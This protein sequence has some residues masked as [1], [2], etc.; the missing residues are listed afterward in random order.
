MRTNTKYECILLANMDIFCNFYVHF[1]WINNTNL[2]CI[3]MLLK[4]IKMNANC[5]F[6]FLLQ[7]LCPRFSPTEIQNICWSDGEK[8]A[9]S[10]ST[11]CGLH[12]PPHRALCYQCPAHQLRICCKLPY[13]AF[14]CKLRPVCMC[15]WFFLFS[16][17][18]DRGLHNWLTLKINWKL[19]IIRD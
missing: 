9:P 5:P 4:D 19:E 18:H 12:L 14:R 2:Y 11:P 8:S 17:S 16:L 7:I 10:C 15:L 1:F 6:N 13:K 3:I